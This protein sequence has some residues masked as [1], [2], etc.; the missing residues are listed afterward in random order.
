MEQIT[1]QIFNNLKPN[2]ELVVSF[3]KKELLNFHAGQVSQDSIGDIEVA[4]YGS[5]MPVKQLGT[6]RRPE[7]GILA[8][9]PWD[10][11]ILADIQ[12][13]I[14]RVASN[15]S[16]VSDG[17][18]VRVSAPP[19]TTQR[20]QELIREVHQILEEARISIRR[21]REQVWKEFQDLEKAKEI[22]EDEKFRAKDELQKMVDDYNEKIETMGGQKQ[23]EIAG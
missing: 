12:K 14:L 23:T 10:K 2:L 8:I 9:E 19:L 21:Q 15:L 20:R 4:C 18:R 16:V 7:P 11:E 13:A 22:S 1:K 5:K 17:E 3:L 6:M